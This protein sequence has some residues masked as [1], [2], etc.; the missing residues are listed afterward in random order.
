M[1]ESGASRNRLGLGAWIVL[2]T[3]AP[4]P[5]AGGEWL[6]AGESPGHEQNVDPRVEYRPVVGAPRLVV[7]SESL[8]PEIQPGR[9][10]NN[11]G[12]AM[13]D[14]RL[15]MAWRSSLVHFASRGARLLVVS[16]PDQGESWDFETEV[17]LGADVREPFLVSFEGRLVLSFF[18]GGTNPLGFEPQQMWRT[19]Y[20][21]PQQW[22]ELETWGEPGE[23][24]WD[25]K[26]R[27]DRVWMTSY[28]GNHYGLL[29]PELELR[30]QVSDDGWN[31]E[32]VASEGPVVYLGGVSE[33]SFEF[34]GD[35][36]LWAVTRNE[37]GD[38]SGFGSHLAVAEPDDW[39]NWD[40][41]EESDPKRYDSPRLFRHRDEIYMVARRDI[42]GPYDRGW[43][44]FPLPMQRLIYLALY[45]LRP[46]LTALYRIDRENRRVEHVQNLPSAADTAFPSIIQTGPD[47]FLVANYTS[48]ASHLWKTWLFGQVSPWGTQI[49]LIPI[50]FEP[51]G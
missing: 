21:G 20:E 11:V 7:P 50:A 29:V 37:D 39:G 40:F 24:P 6:A 14:G 42:L 41:P 15:F 5:A 48:P 22:S 47:D 10:N 45:S 12:I 17:A 43:D 44:I 4:R 27:G 35:R 30:F 25:F 28:I 38:R 31:F 8:P 36:R 3:V 23:V 51:V 9:S 16:S 18:E 33:A 32:P 49:Y 34:D 13:H 1:K 2:A 26:V 19:V 46:K